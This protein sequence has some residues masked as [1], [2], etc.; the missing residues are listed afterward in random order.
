MKSAAVM[1][2][3]TC[4]GAFHNIIDSSFGRP[5]NDDIKLD[6]LVFIARD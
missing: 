3:V 5:A 1:Q 6:L 2:I 4:C